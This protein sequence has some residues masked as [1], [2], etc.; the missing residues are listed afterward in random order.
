MVAWI[1]VIAV[2]TTQVA[3]AAYL[4]PSEKSA[5]VEQSM[6]SCAKGMIGGDQSN[7]CKAHNDA[8]AQLK[9]DQAPSFTTAPFIVVSA[10]TS[11][12]LSSDRGESRLTSYRVDRLAP[13][14]SPPLFL[15]LLVLRV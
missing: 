14:G 7:L 2:F 9:A 4:C 1:A 12:D 5:A 8:P 11:V 6:E 3:V 10:V 15:R 13:D